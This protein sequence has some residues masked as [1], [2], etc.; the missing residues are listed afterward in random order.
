VEAIEALAIIHREQG[1]LAYNTTCRYEV[2]QRVAEDRGTA[3]KCEG[4]LS[5]SIRI[6]QPIRVIGPSTPEEFLRQGHRFGEL[7]NGSK[8]SFTAAGS[9][10][11]YRVV[12]CD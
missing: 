4:R 12:A 1:F 2:G 9:A 6:M 11:F 7:M 8:S 10:N 3:N 5:I